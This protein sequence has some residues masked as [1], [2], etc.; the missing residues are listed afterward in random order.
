MPQKAAFHC[1]DDSNYDVC[2]HVR[3]LDIQLP[4]ITDCYH[5][6]IAAY[7]HTLIGSPSA[8]LAANMLMIMR[9]QEGVCLMFFQA[10]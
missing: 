3:Y 1:M 4:K 6:A 2:Y 9:R 8:D 7:A 10:V 5:L